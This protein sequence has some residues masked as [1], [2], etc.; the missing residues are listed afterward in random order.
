VENNPDQQQRA[1]HAEHA[2]VEFRGF[3]EDGKR[4]QTAWPRTLSRRRRLRHQRSLARRDRR[5]QNMPAVVR[6]KPWRLR[7]ATSAINRRP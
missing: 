3:E 5:P 7:R 4:R 2:R 6:I 1:D